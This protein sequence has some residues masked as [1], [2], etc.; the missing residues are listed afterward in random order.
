MNYVFELEDA[1]AAARKVSCAFSAIP[2]TLR[3][4]LPR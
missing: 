4:F 1:G 2:G 3:V